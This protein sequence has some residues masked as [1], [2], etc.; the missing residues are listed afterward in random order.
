VNSIAVILRELRAA[1]VRIPDLLA[2]APMRLAQSAPVTPEFPH[3]RHTDLTYTVRSDDPEARRDP[4]GEVER[5][6]RSLQIALADHLVLTGMKLTPAINRVAA[7]VGVEPALL[8]HWRKEASRKKKK[9]TGWDGHLK[10]AKRWVQL[11]F[12][13]LRKTLPSPEARE[14]LFHIVSKK[15]RADSFSITTV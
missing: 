12:A 11:E 5:T 6:K 13:R 3:H 7:G 14:E 2:E 8:S 10:N 1:G 15:A 4:A 9:N